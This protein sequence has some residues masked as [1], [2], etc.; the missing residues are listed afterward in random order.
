MNKK[1]YVIILNYNGWRDTLPCVESVLKSQYDTYRI[2]ICDN[3]STDDSL[4]KIRQWAKIGFSIEDLIE[5]NTPDRIKKNIFPQSEKPLDFIEITEGDIEAEKL[6]PTSQKIVLIRNFRNKGYSG[7]NNVGLKYMQLCGDGDFA[8]ILNNDTV[9]D[10]MAMA[11]LVSQ[12]EKGKYICS[13]VVLHYWNPDVVQHIGM[14]WKKFSL[15]NIFI[16]QNTLYENLRPDIPLEIHNGASFMISYDLLNKIKKLDESYFLCFEENSLVVRSKPYGYKPS[17]NR[18]A[19]IYH[20]GGRSI[21]KISD[22][23]IYHLH[24]SRTIFVMREYK[25]YAPL[26]LYKSLEQIVRFVF[27]FDFKGIKAIVKGV[28]DGFREF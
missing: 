14:S 22:R 12:M 7:G 9:V 2:I 18:K 17:Y 19:I 1:V 28:R 15:K 13:S 26:L 10:K 5:K 16:C 23:R 25:I 3:F 4:V 11:E 24:R 27:R 8:W 6:V 20:R 21:G